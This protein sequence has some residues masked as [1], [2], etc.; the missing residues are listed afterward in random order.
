MS[1]HQFQRILVSRLRFMGDIVLTT[2]LLRALRRAFPQARISYLAE[3]PFVQVLAHHPDVN[4]LIEL[5]R[6]GTLGAQIGLV[7]SLRCQ[8]FDLAI[9]LLGNPRSALLLWL[10]GAA[11]RVGFDYRG[12]RLLYTTVVRREPR[13]MTAIEFH[14]QV[15]GA[16]GLPVAGMQTCLVTSAEED[17]WAKEF[18]KAKGIAPGERLLVMHPGASW[19]AK[20][21]FPDRFGE[22]ARRLVKEL[23]IRV[24]ITVGPGEEELAQGVASIARE[25]IV[26]GVMPIRHVMAVVKRAQVL[27]A[28]DCGVLHLGPALGVPTVGVFGP[29]EP[30]I[31]FPYAEE[32][33]HRVVHKELAC[34]RCHRD[35]CAE[36]R[37]MEAI[38]VE[39]VF[40][41][42]VQALAHKQAE[43]PT[44]YTIGHSTLS[45]EEFLA[46]LRAH[47]IA[48]VVDV[49]RFPTSRRYPHFC[50]EELA[51]ALKGQG[52]DYRWLGDTLGGFRSGGYEGYMHTAP[53]LAGLN[54]LMELARGMPTAVVC[55]E[56]LFFR[57]HRRFIADE[58]V[59]HQWRVLH[60][61]DGRRTQEHRLRHETTGHETNRGVQHDHA[62]DSG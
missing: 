49:R 14:L 7:R 16:L 50:R 6:Q 19:P 54:T 26:L 52:I 61:L 5:E 3:A 12:R 59:R 34:S 10:S 32:A 47:G 2:P 21:W 35:F 27:V 44:I 1:A 39:D 18:L 13:P 56:A 53:F 41:A 40:S 55:S 23:G 11:Q 25:A 57:C 28:N 20:R 29:G 24:L 46:R 37:C 22:L 9:D 62:Q 38:Q 31:W 48:R 36:L 30:E 17:H 58:L 42:V 33:G 60:I 43:M 45:S 15:L 51:S 4:E 8:H